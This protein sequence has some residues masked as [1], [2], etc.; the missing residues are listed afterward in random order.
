MVVVWCR[1]DAARQDTPTYLDPPAFAHAAPAARFA[2]VHHAGSVGSR[3]E[4][5]GG[6][7]QQSQKYSLWALFSP[8]R[9][10]DEIGGNVCIKKTQ[11]LRLHSTRLSSGPRDAHYV[12]FL[13][14]RAHATGPVSRISGTRG[15]RATR[16]AIESSGMRDLRGTGSERRRGCQRRGFELNGRDG[17]SSIETQKKGPSIRWL[18][19]RLKLVDSPSWVVNFRKHYVIRLER[20]LLRTPDGHR[21]GRVSAPATLA[22]THL[23]LNLNL[24]P[25]T[26]HLET[27]YPRLLLTL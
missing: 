17:E 6:G 8:K 22:C 14:Q 5:M 24:A 2:C 7:T 23:N 1:R 3:E 27:T 11:A 16:S 18:L 15:T 21:H 19:R 12:A 13:P 9:G 20:A 4:R 25:R 10:D 26:S